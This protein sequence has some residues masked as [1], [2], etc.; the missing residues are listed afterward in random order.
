MRAPLNFTARARA[1][2]LPLLAASCWVAAGPVW[3][4]PDAGSQIRRY[5]EET[6]ERLA[7]KPAAG[8]DRPA[9]A[10]GPAKEAAQA[11]TVDM[12]VSN[13]VV[14]GVTRFTQQE[15]EAALTPFSGRRLDTASLHAAAD[16]L[17]KL[18][19][20][21]GYFVAKVFVMPQT[22]VGG[23][24]HLE[25]F[26]GLLESGGIEVVN[27][28][29]RINSP[30]IQA[31]LERHLVTGE[32]IHRRAFER[33]LLL[34]EDLPGVHTSSVL[35]PGQH[36]GTARLRL[37][38][39]D[40]PVFAGN[41]DADN[42]G[43]E[44]TGR[45]RLGTTLYLNSPTRRGEQWAVRLV[46]SGERSNYAYLNY[47]HPVSASGTRVGVSVDY[48]RYRSDFINGL[49]LS[50]G[51]AT[52]ARVY[53]T[54][55]LIRSRHG[56]LHL[57]ADLSAL[58]LHDRNSLGVNG[59]RRA[60]VAALS[61]AGDDDHEVLGSGLTEFE[62]SLAVGRLDVVGN[63]LYRNLDSSTAQTDR[64]FTR[65][66][67]HVSRLQ[68]LG[69][70]WSI[71]GKLRGQ[72]ANAN[73][74]SSQKIYLGG[75]TSNAGYPLGEVGGDQGIE[76]HLALRKEFLAPWGGSAQAGIFYEQGWTQIHK[77]PWLGWQGSNGTLPNHVTLKSV[78]LSLSQTWPNAWVLRGRV[79]YQ[80]GDN[81]LRDPATGK[82]S[83]GRGGK[84]RAW[85]QVVRYF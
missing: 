58:A 8:G 4:A 77:N 54:H 71:Y 73:L 37:T 57:R 43:N 82:A 7:P 34:A 18:Y 68:H 14:H 35:Y 42:F 66:N 32:P 20:Q 26:E 78:G 59:K 46:T 19:R 53:L 62:T 50:K 1:W 63:D 49:G 2:L 51:E 24:V 15:V 21:Q 67:A 5:H 74:D 61:L 64:S 39:Q 29:T 60:Q 28:G 56:N 84:A 81:P 48:F 22:V 23:V 72:V 25:V 3:A 79:G 11:S 41:V 70:T 31:I 27:P 6:R 76:A 47:L 55:P 40:T 36:V 44:A 65:L 17:N 45:E 10:P 52:D 75:A 80:L 38:V 69:S 30:V 9:V 85:I 12:H 33:A 83:D 13:L 16:A